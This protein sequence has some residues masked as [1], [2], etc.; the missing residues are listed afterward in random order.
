VS[1]RPP[2]LSEW[3]RLPAEPYA[4][5]WVLYCHQM[6]ALKGEVY[7]LKKREES[8]KA[9]VAERDSAITDLHDRLTKSQ[10]SLART[11]GAF[12]IIIIIIIILLLLLLIIIIIIT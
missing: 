6:K 3:G 7:R 5:D 1:H 8:L 10:D 11:K 2:R 9:E 4:H 12:I